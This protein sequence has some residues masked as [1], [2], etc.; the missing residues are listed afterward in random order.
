METWE[1]RISHP[2]LNAFRVLRGHNRSDLAMKA[3]MQK[4][5]WDEKWAHLLRQQELLSE[6]G[7]RLRSKEEFKEEAFQR[8]QRVRE[9]LSRLETLLRSV[10]ERGACFNWDSLK[11]TA[12]FSIATPIKPTLLPVPVAP[13]RPEMI[14]I[15]PLKFFESIIPFVK[16]KVL[17]ENKEANLLQDRRFSALISNWEKAKTDIDDENRKILAIYEGDLRSWSD[18]RDVFT[19]T[20][21]EQHKQIDEL[22]KRYEAFDREALVCYWDAVLNRSEYPDAFP[23]SWLLDYIPETKTIV[24]EYGLPNLQQIPNVKEVKY[25][26]SRNELEDLELSQ[27]AFQK[28]YDFVLY[29]VCLRTLLE[30]L[31]TDYVGA[32]QTAVFNGWVTATD[33]ATGKETTSCILSLQVKKEDFLSLNLAQ[34]DPK[35]CFKKFKGVSGAR[36]ME[37]TPVRPVL[38]L[39]KDDKRFI[40]AY[41]VADSLQSSTNLASMDWL[42]FE[43]LIRELFEKEFQSNG[44]EVKITQA[45]RDG[46]VDAIAF[47]PDPIRGGKI[48]IQAKRYTN[49]V[50]VSA[51]R[52]LYGTVLNEGATKGI[53]VTTADYGSDSYEF[54]KD[55]PLTLLS[56]SELLYLLQ[57]HGHAARIDLQDAKR[58]NL[59]RERQQRSISHGA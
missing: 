57:K 40:P 58:E 27:A 16:R 46:G 14:P 8:T 42:D 41:Q 39:V 53:L 25:V 56:G 29:Q 43:N 47:D 35:I 22:K 7:A 55:K 34:V 26:A 28:L 21:R 23:K 2:G 48:V 10:A 11:E 38:Q 24:C 32:I 51:V 54:A 19:E 52:D 1:I 37:L 4:S 5:A 33:K 36:L 30:L 49:V 13:E 15:P 31:A 9:E 50:G 3:A 59:E 44:G 18:Q 6:R 17:N 45:S 12:K 20:Q